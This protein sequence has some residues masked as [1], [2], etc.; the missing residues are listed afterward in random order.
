MKSLEAYLLSPF[1]GR[2]P[3]LVRLSK[4]KRLK[5]HDVRSPSASHV[6]ATELTIAVES[7][8]AVV[9]TADEAEPQQQAAAAL[10]SSFTVEAAPVTPATGAIGGSAQHKPAIKVGLLY[11]VK[12]RSAPGYPGW[13]SV[14]MPCV[15]VIEDKGDGEFVVAQTKKTAVL[16]AGTKRIVCADDLVELEEPRTGEDELAGRGVA[17]SCNS[18][19]YKL[20]RVVA[21]AHQKQTAAENRAKRETAMRKTWE[22]GD[23]VIIYIYRGIISSFFI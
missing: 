12:K 1:I 4:S 9:A 7:L 5:F 22:K 18:D 13:H 10:E 19:D 6:P 15:R 14:R 11:T 8:P 17:R 16:K 20:R 2:R 23:W 3:E 21:K